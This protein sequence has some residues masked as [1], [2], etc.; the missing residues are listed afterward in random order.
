M[1]IFFLRTSVIFNAWS[2]C[3]N[4]TENLMIHEIDPFMKM[5]NL[6]SALNIITSLKKYYI[7][8]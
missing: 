6:K 7:K 8:P 1:I 4:R 2:G 5:T 3:M